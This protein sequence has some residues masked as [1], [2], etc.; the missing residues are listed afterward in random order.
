MI[1][2][3]PGKGMFWAVFISIVVANVIIVAT[4]IPYLS[5]VIT[6]AFFG[7]ILW[8]LIGWANQK[9]RDGE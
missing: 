2:M 5:W 1:S 9:Q 6:V 7:W 8:G 3:F 4:G